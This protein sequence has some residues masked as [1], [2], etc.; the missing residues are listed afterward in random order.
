MKITVKLIDVSHREWLEEVSSYDD[1]RKIR[2]ESNKDTY[3]YTATQEAYIETLLI[4]NKFN[5]QG[6]TII[7]KTGGL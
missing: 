1:L 5:E 6:K 4:I 2:M 3:W 7:I